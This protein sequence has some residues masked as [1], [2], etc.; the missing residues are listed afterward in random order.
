VVWENVHGIYS[1]EVRADAHQPLRINK[2][3]FIYFPWEAG[4]SAGA[5]SFGSTGGTAGGST[6]GSTVAV[7]QVS[8]SRPHSWTACVHENHKQSIQ[9]L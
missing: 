7:H 6:D 5:S 3:D 8:G 4:G 2:T 1:S 9:S